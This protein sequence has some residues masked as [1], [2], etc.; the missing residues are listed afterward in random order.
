MPFIKLL[1]KKYDDDFA[2]EIKNWSLSDDQITLLEG[3]SGAGKSSVIKL[4]I[5][6]DAADE[7]EWTLNGE[8]MNLL[9]PPERNFSVVFQNYD[10]FPHMTARENII[11]FAKCRNIHEKNYLNDL[12]ELTEYLKIQSILDR[13]PETLSGGE[14]QRVALS[15]ALISKPK[16]IF[17][18]E[19]FS[20]LDSSN[21]ANARNLLSGIIKL[22]K[23]PCLLV[24]HDEDDK[25]MWRSES[26]TLVGEKIKT[27]IKSE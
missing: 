17:L 19:P 7:C 5:G 25:K 10:L 23:I 2:I 15:R 20:A 14:K 12:Q 8:F 21:K 24:S 13:Y 4:L 6:L 1:K 27:I 26:Y 3:P 9:R 18:D 22:R 11:F 16:M